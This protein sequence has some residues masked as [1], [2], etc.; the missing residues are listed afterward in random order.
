MTTGLLASERSSLDAD[1]NVA[2]ICDIYLREF[3]S[4]LESD[5]PGSAND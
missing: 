2:A 3:H 4:E 5:P 1:P